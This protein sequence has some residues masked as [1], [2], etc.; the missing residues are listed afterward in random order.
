MLDIG[1]GPKSE[2][3]QQAAYRAVHS[4]RAR[5]PG[6]SFHYRLSGCIHGVGQPAAPVPR[7]RKAA[8]DV[9]SSSWP[10]MSRP[11]TPA[12]AAQMAGLSPSHDERKTTLLRATIGAQDCILLLRV[13]F[14]EQFHQSGIA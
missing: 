4:L 11:S 9:A 12:V 8:A 5:A 2:S 3:L 10:G 7:W 6:M 13:L 1:A 14:R